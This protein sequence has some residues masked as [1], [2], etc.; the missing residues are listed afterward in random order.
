MSQYDSNG[1]YG[2]CYN[3]DS[4]WYYC[5]GHSMTVMGIIVYITI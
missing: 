3:C 1:Y 4:N 2:V 5:I